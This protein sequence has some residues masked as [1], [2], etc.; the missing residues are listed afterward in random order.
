[1]GLSCVEFYPRLVKGQSA[2]QWN[3]AVFCPAKAGK[4][5]PT[6]L[7]AIFSNS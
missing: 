5:I 7:F 3:E 2:V 4:K 6:A 1:M